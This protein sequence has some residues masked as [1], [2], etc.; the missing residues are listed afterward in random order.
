MKAG[1]NEEAYQTIDK[2]LE[3]DPNNATTH[4]NYGWGH[5]HQGQHLKALEHFKTAL[6]IDPLNDWAK[7]GMLE[8]MKSKFLPYRLLLQIMLKLEGLGRSAQ[9][10]AIIGGYVVFRL[11]SGLAK[12]NEALRPLLVP[13]LILL[14]LLFL[15]TWI[16][17]PLMNLYMLTNPY[18][19]FDAG[20]RR[21]AIG[22]YGRG[23]PGGFIV[24]FGSLFADGMGSIAATGDHLLFAH[25][26]LGVDVQ[27]GFEIR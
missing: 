6:Q 27:P 21:P 19:R 22:S 17:G 11:L 26:T 18:G 3:E 20:G 1:K 4:A 13:V 12:E 9:W 25:G 5:L 7:A 24:V 2:A 8:A 10:A 14:G 16:L 15:S 23:G